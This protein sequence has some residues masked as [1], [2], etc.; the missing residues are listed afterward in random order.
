MRI[1]AGRSTHRSG[2]TLVRAISKTQKKLF[3]ACFVIL[4]YA[5]WGINVMSLKAR[6]I[7]AQENVVENESDPPSN[8]QYTTVTM[9]AEDVLSVTFDVTARALTECSNRRVEEH[10]EVLQDLWPPLQRVARRRFVSL[11][12]LQRLSESV[13]LHTGCKHVRANA[14]IRQVGEEREVPWGR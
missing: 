14:D 8:A 1:V 6:S 5:E 7:G 13:C 2:P 9:M 11:T 3:S 10:M 4:E 12:L